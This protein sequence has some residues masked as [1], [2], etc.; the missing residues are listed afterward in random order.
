ME[1]ALARHKAGRAVAAPERKGAPRTL[2]DYPASKR[3]SARACAH[4]H[5]A[6]DFRRE[7]RQAEGKWTKD[8]LWVYPLPEN[9]GLEMDTDRGDRVKGVRAAS[10]AAKAG[11]KAGD[12]LV[13]VGGRNISSF[14]ELQYAL[15]RAPAKGALA[16]RYERGGK[17]IGVEVTLGAGWRKTDVSWRWSLRGVGPAPG[18][19]G[20]DL[21]VK[22]K[23]ALG[24]GPGRLAYEQG[25]FV[26]EAARQAGLRQ[27]DV[28]V[29]VDG[30]ARSLSGRQFLAHVRLNYKVGDRV[31]YDLLR[32]GKHAAVTM[33]LREW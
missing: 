16:V 20:A 30:R 13:S 17:E 12:R 11:L 2:A 7:A 14:A 3:L 26:G 33:T 21:S 27:G 18:V 1:Q 15:H 23:R 6:Y 8:E 31:T 5:H 24:L 28:I 4:C 29:G 32:D 19:R 10:A 25:A 9:V 22:E